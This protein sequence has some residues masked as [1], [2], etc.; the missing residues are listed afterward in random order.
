[1]ELKPKIYVSGHKAPI[2]GK[3]KNLRELENILGSS[4]KLG[5]GFGGF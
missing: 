4:M 3:E 2:R 5:R 1:M